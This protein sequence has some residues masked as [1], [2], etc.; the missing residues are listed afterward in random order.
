MQVFG[1]ERVAPIYCLFSM[2]P[3]LGDVTTGD[4]ESQQRVDPDVASAVLPATILGH[5][6]PAALLGVLPMTATEVSRSPFTLQSV[7][8][9]LFY[10]SPLTVAA[11]TMAGA[12]AIK[13]LRARRS[14]PARERHIDDGGEAPRRGLPEGK[15]ACETPAL[16]TA[17]A[18]AFGLQALK[19]LSTATWVVRSYHGALSRL[20]GLS[21]VTGALERLLLGNGPR[22]GAAAAAVVSVEPLVAYRVATAVFGL[23]T[24]WD[25][26]R[27]GYA[28]TG[29]AA[30]VAVTFYG[31]QDTC[32]AG[33]AYAGLWYWRESVLGRLRRRRARRA[34][35][36]VPRSGKR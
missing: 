2:H 24:V 20:P 8:C 10:L 4:C 18:V 6:L 34:S 7:V 22:D 29:E 23:Y 15:R 5:L 27:R 19:H 1:V 36:S 11:L 21:L 26:R 33:A 3:E 13:W 16:K 9:H 32:G 28:T 31:L 12:R 35:S 30:R 14:A 25:L 17:Y